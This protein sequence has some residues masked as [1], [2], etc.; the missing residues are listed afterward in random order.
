MF[1]KVFPGPIASNRSFTLKDVRG[2]QNP[3]NKLSRSSQDSP[4]QIAAAVSDQD[5]LFLDQ[6]HGRF[7]IGGNLEDWK[8]NRVMA[9][10]FQGQLGLALACC[11]TAIA[12]GRKLPQMAHQVARKV[13]P[14]VDQPGEQFAALATE[15][16]RKEKNQFARK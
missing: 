7:Q 15:Y 9:H 14:D 5:F 6:F 4:L 12:V 11:R 1:H 8:S 3:S 2:G 13:V 10:G 16:I